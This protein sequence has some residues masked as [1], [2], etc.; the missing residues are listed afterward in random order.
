MVILKYAY[1]FCAFAVRNALQTATGANLGSIHTDEAIGRAAEE[2][3]P[4]QDLVELHPYAPIILAAMDGAWRAI[5]KIANQ[6]EG[7]EK[8]EQLPANGQQNS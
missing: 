6:A 1:N 2:I 4:S 8:L 3:K 5:W 7:G